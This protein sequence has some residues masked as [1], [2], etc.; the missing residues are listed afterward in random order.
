MTEANRPIPTTSPN[1]SESFNGDLIIDIGVL[2]VHGAG[3]SF[4]EALRDL[5]DA[6]EGH[7]EA[8]DGPQTRELFA[9]EDEATLGPGL[10]WM[11]AQIPELRRRLQEVEDLLYASD[12]TAPSTTGGELVHGNSR[13]WLREDFTHGDELEA[14]GPGPRPAV[15]PDGPVPRNLSLGMTKEEFDH[16]NAYGSDS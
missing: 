13:S 5:R 1:A 14:E 15:N 11:R 2:G 6:I 4:D 16:I 3:A 7:I 8:L 12:A 10:V 9:R